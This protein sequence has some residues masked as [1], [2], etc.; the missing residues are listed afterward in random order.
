M[1]ETE[2]IYSYREFRGKNAE[3][4]GEMVLTVPLFL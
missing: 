4:R 2:K 3:N 1:W